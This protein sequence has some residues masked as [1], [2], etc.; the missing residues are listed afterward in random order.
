MKFHLCGVEPQSKV[1]SLHIHIKTSE[2]TE[3]W[4]HPSVLIKHIKHLFGV[5]HLRGVALWV[6]A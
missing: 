3:P 5:H 6:W 1:Q 2:P 4:L